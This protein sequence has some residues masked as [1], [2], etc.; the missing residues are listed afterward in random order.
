MRGAA[1]AER[2]GRAGGAGRRG[3]SV[4]GGRGR[5][6]GMFGRW[7]RRGRFAREE[8]GKG[9]CFMKPEAINTIVTA[10]L[11]AL[12][13]C[14]MILLLRRHLKFLV[15]TLK[16]RRRLYLGVRDQRVS[17]LENH[18]ETLLQSVFLK[19]TPVGGF[20]IVSGVLFVSMLIVG[21]QNTNPPAAW[22]MSL[23]AAAMP[24]LLLRIRAESVSRRGSHEGESL[25]AAFL[26]QYRIEN[27]NVYETLEKLVAGGDAFR[28]CR[29]H[30]FRLL[31][32]IRSA[33]SGERLQ[34]A[35][36]A[37]ARAINTNWSRMLAYNIRLSAE[38][39]MNVSPGVEDILVQ[40]R[41][42][43]SL[44]EERKRLNAESVRIVVFLVPSL[45]LGSVFLSVRFLGIPAALFV[46]NQVGTPEGFVLLSLIV[47]LFFVNLV[48]IELVT[49]Q[50]MDY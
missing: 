23:I 8:N 48:L 20:L 14:G 49:R 39:G 9:D 44:M 45:Y 1:R 10:A 28:V 5:A 34:R 18:L 26:N 3:L 33:G 32:E 21:L 38:Q 43:R 22:F 46:K 25:V 27:Y 13:T 7:A 37:F 40:L 50:K 17:G 16:T 35:T 12:F 42:A 47:F 6:V 24:Y 4:A 15:L 2:R 41:E 30:L 19:K 11:Y 31:L 29:K 36:D